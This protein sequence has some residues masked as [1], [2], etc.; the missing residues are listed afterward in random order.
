MQVTQS[1]ATI[2]PLTPSGIGT[3]QALA[4]YVLSGQASRA[5]LLSLSVGMELV[6]T[7][8]NATLGAAALLLMVRSLR[9]RRTLAAARSEHGASGSDPGAAEPP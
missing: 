7:V 1:L 9:W 4:V 5:A 2:L 6:L 8:W 3:E